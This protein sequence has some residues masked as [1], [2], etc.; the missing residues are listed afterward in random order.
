MTQ[1]KRSNLRKLPHRVRSLMNAKNR[2]LSLMT[3]L[4]LVLDL[5]M[6]GGKS[7]GGKSKQ[8]PLYICH[9]R[10]MSIAGSK[11]CGEK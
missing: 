7:V 11:S 4:N 9:I 6:N 10:A 3:A 5:K 2:E 1:R 8:S